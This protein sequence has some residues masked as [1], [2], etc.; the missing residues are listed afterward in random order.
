MPETP[1]PIDL[2]DAFRIAAEDG[3]WAVRG[4]AVQSY[5]SLEQSLCQLFALLAGTTD[6]VAS[7]IFFKIPAGARNRILEKL[8]HRKFPNDFALFR[9]SLIKLLQPLDNERNEIV[10]WNVITNVIGD[11][12]GRATVSVSLRPP[13]FVHNVT[14]APEKDTFSLLKFMEKCGFFARLL[15]MFRFVMTTDSDHFS[16]EDK[17]QWLAIFAQPIVYPPPAGHPLSLKLA[18]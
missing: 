14:N 7:I 6:E 11:D 3:F 18:G 2:A 16:Q 15:N 9:N 17:S 12:Q 13:G 4:K 5:A 1:P 10:H 8:F